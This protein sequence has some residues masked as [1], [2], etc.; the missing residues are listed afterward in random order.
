M[1][2]F[3]LTATYL[4]TWGV[5]VL[6]A[7][8]QLA[9]GQGMA[10][11]EA[12]QQHREGQVFFADGD[13]DIRYKDMVLQADHVQYDSSTDQAVARDHVH[14][15]QDTLDL[16]ADRAELNLRTG[17]GTFEHVSGTEHIVR[18]PNPAILI[19]P[20]P[21]TFRADLV[22]RLNENTYRMHKAWLTVCEPQ[23][24]TWT[25]SASEATLHVDQRVAFVN[26]NFRIFRVPLFYFP[27]T[28]AP[29]G[30]RVRQSGFLMPEIG[31]SKV[32]G[33][34]LGDSYYWAP[35]DWADA[36]A[37]AQLLSLRGWSEN[38]Q[39]RMRPSDN[40]SLTADYD[41]LE[42]RLHEGGSSLGVKFS[43]LLPDGWR[44]VADLNNLTSYIFRLEFAPTFNEA[45]N[46]EVTSSAFVTNNFGSYSINFAANDYKNFLT[47]QPQTA[48]VI[49]QAPEMRFQSVDQEPWKQLP[50]YFGFDVLA[51]AASRSDTVI[52][53]PAMVQRSMIA[54]SVTLPIDMGPWLHVT[55]TFTFRS[56]RYGAQQA[57]GNVADEAIFRDTEEVGID[58]RP[59]SFERTWGTE[60]SKWKHTIEPAVVYSYVTG[61]NNFGDFL[62]FD[63][64]DTLTDTNEVEYSITQRL[65]H[66]VGTKQSDELVSWKVVQKYYFDP[67]FG[68][69]LVPGQRNVFQALDSLTPFAF[70]DEPRRFSPIVSDIK[71]SPGG[72]YDAEFR[73]DYDP[74][75]HE[76]TTRELLFS[77]KARDDFKFSVASYAVNATPILQPP[78]DQ[79]RATIS[80]GDLNRRGWN[81]ALSAGYDIR[82]RLVQNEVG[83]VSY[84]GSCC[85][86]AFEYR[87]LTLGPVQRGNEYR[88][89]LVIANLGMFGN[90]RR[91]EVI[92]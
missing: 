59:A 57:N 13:V 2:I 83:Q 21:L 22:E 74:L 58:I 41:G 90:M 42:D 7:Q 52:K 31:N 84:N 80:Y 11:L 33:F 36:T 47:A 17:Q 70:A 77:L 73:T 51:D 16:H 40:I 89:S 8:T 78:S 3:L 65:F 39:V 63:E 61:V 85:G 67:T 88:A 92:Y 38:A 82:Q 86:L 46:S 62:R 35:T 87:R 48:V 9:T 71:F 53:T 15:V 1:A 34:M 20:N 68:G 26:A 60:A 55:P 5:D 49:R 30:R 37:G 75:R 64:N 4:C 28:T 27:Y 79:I 14:F 32:K 12:K 23:H 10:Q 54:P 56:M 24:P 91:R 45:V 18:R 69:A 6:L 50:I 43:A 76:F 81:G 29:A 25:F 66:R 19:T 44:A 72:S